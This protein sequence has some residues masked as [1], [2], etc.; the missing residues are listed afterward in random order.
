M[1]PTSTPAIVASSVINSKT[2]TSPFNVR[3]MEVKIVHKTFVPIGGRQQLGAALL[4]ALSHTVEVAR[5]LDSLL[6]CS[7]ILNSKAE[8][9]TAV[10]SDFRTILY[11]PSTRGNR[12]NLPSRLRACGSSSFKWAAPTVQHSFPQKLE[13]SVPRGTNPRQLHRLNGVDLVSAP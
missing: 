13:S 11:Q 9:T 8:Y 7:Q 12:L 3:P 5:F 10:G 4:P 2:W 6:Q 1:D